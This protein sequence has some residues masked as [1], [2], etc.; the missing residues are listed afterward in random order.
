[1]ASDIEI[2]A[3]ARRTPVEQQGPPSHPCH[4][5]GERNF[6]IEIKH[7]RRIDEG[8]DEDSRRPITAKIIETC[9]ASLCE[10]IPP[11]AQVAP[12]GAF[13]GCEAFQRGSCQFRL[14]FS[15]TPY[16]SEKQGKRA[17]GVFMLRCTLVR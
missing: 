11:A 15:D 14:F 8:G 12:F 3:L 1:M 13:V 6:I 17:R 7:M 4:S 9:R 16:Q 10:H 5:L 2:K